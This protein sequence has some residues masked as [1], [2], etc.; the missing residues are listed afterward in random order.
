MAKRD[1]TRINLNLSDEIIEKVD[2]FAS[3]NGISRTSAVSVIITQYFR[4]DE[5]MKN[6]SLLTDMLQQKK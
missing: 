2:K 3:D 1:L 6:I 4:Q 5:A